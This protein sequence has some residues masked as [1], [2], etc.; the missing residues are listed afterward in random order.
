MPTTSLLISEVLQVY[1]AYK[2]HKPFALALTEDEDTDIWESVRARL[3]TLDIRA[4]DTSVPED[5]ENILG[6]IGDQIDQLN[7]NVTKLG[8]EARN[9]LM[10]MHAVSKGQVEEV[11]QLCKDLDNATQCKDYSGATAL[12]TAATTNQ[13]GITRFLLENGFEVDLLDASKRTPLDLAS[14]K[15]SLSTAEVRIEHRADVNHADGHGSTPLMRAAFKGHLEL[16][17]VV[18]VDLVLT[19]AAWP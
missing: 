7:Q 14:L 10:L 11:R 16:V 4:C 1:L 15:K 19:R 18:R 9:T 13:A 8:E 3:E 12:H 2:E 5:K 6:L 17:Q